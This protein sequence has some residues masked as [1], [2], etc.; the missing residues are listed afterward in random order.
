MVRRRLR[1]RVGAI[2]ARLLGA[3]HRAAPL[4]GCVFCCESSRCLSR[5]H[6]IAFLGGPHMARQHMRRN[7]GRIGR[8]LL[9]SLFLHAQVLVPL[10]VWV[11]WW[12]KPEDNEVGLSFESI[13]DDELPPNLPAIEKPAG[14]KKATKLPE[15]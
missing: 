5:E 15:R 9:L 10:V 11:F 2:L 12:G 1:A 3:P 8:G 7:R 6:R 13:K 14:P 4:V